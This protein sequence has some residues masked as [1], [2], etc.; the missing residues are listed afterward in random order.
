MALLQALRPAR[1]AGDQGRAF[2]DAEEPLEIFRRLLIGSEGTLGFVS[3]V[4]FETVA[5]PAVTTTAWIHFPGID[6]AIGPVTDLVEMGATAVELMVAPALITGTGFFP[7]APG[8]MPA[9]VPVGR[10]GRTE[11]VADLAMAMLTNGYLTNKVVT[12]DGG[13]YPT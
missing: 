4:V 5:Q 6:A 11:D 13:L 10:L 7:A 1:A 8:E 2:L 3:E 12:V 9:P